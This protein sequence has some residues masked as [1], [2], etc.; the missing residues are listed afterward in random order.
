MCFYLWAQQASALATVQGAVCVV[1]SLAGLSQEPTFCNINT[2]FLITTRVVF[3]PVTWHF[4]SESALVAEADFPWDLQKA[5][6]SHD[7]LH[8]ALELN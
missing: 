7:S 6:V 3:L 5:P 8:S 1:A 2:A 4:P